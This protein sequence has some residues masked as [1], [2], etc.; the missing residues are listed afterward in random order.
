MSSVLEKNYAL[1]KIEKI[2]AEKIKEV[3][4]K[5]DSISD[6]QATEDNSR[7]TSINS[8]LKIQKE[9]INKSNSEVLFHKAQLFVEEKKE[10]AVP[11]SQNV[12]KN[13]KNEVRNENE[14]KNEIQ[15]NSEK[16]VN[17]EKEL[18]KKINIEKEKKEEKISKVEKNQEIKDKSNDGFSQSY[19]IHDFNERPPKIIS[20]F[21]TDFSYETIG[22]NGEINKMPNYIFNHVL[23]NHENSRYSK[24]S[25]SK[26]NSGKV[27]TLIYYSP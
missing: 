8:S 24:I 13:E 3:D 6:S 20:L 15:L 22:E 23:F 14:R 10:N 9:E 11:E 1:E 16:N 5:N 2:N 17:K 4:S 21:N 19:N 12:P 26:R 7:N 25:M 27:S 18:I